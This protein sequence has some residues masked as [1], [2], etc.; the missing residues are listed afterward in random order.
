MTDLDSCTTI[1][2]IKYHWRP[3]HLNSHKPYEGSMK[4][5]Y[6]YKL[7]NNWLI[8]I[9]KAVRLRAGYSQDQ[10]IFHGIFDVTDVTKDYLKYRTPYDD[11][12]VIQ[13]EDDTTT[14]A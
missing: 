14:T 5:S 10:F 8:Q 13:L 9:E 6:I 1:C 3:W 4:F 7:P 2:R 12:N 11:H